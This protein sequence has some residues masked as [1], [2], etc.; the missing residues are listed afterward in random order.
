MTE[1]EPEIIQNKEVIEKLKEAEI[2]RNPFKN[3][4]SAQIEK[5]LKYLEEFA[6]EH[7]EYKKDGI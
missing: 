7:P 1:N 3:L 6:E 5:A 4:P 2:K